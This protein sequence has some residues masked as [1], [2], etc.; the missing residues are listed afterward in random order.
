MMSDLD[1]TGSYSVTTVF[2]F[3]AATILKNGTFFTS[4]VSIS[5][6]VFTNMNDVIVLLIT[7]NTGFSPFAKTSLLIISFLILV[8]RVILIHYPVVVSSSK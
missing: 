7:S 1:F 2:S 8:N 5:S 3:V 6:V 4:Y